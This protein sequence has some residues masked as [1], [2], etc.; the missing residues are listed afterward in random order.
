MPAESIPSQPVFFPPQQ[1][2]T[3]FAA[4]DAFFLI[5]PAR[6]IEIGG[7]HLLHSDLLRFIAPASH[8]PRM[9]RRSSIR[10]NPTQDLYEQGAVVPALGLERGFYNVHVRST[11]TE[12]APLPLSHIVFSAGFVLGTETGKLLVANADRLQPWSPGIVRG[13]NTLTASRGSSEQPHSLA[14]LERAIE[15]SPGWYTVTVV[16]GLRDTP[17]EADQSPAE[18]SLPQA[19][20]YE[21]D[22]SQDPEGPTLTRASTYMRSGGMQRWRS[23]EQWMC[24]FLLDPMPTRPSFMAD[25]RKTLNIFHP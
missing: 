18:E 10:R 11:Q 3:F 20:R 8:D 9:P 22:Y 14:S 12:D 17:E 5:D 23:E 13:P 16:A 25:I 2:D 15:I 4:G 24:A 19:Q 7:A 21:D 6:L 1:T